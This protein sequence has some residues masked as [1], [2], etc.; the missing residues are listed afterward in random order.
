MK[1]LLIFLAI[2]FVVFVAR[3]IF[4]HKTGSGN[5]AGSAPTPTNTTGGPVN[6]PGNPPQNV[7]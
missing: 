5:T 2:A 6:T 7:E 3:N 4:G 1:Y